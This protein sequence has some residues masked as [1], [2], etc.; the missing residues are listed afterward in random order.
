MLLA[1][2]GCV[3]DVQPARARSHFLWGLF[4]LA[5]RL[6]GIAGR[7]EPC[8]RQLTDRAAAAHSNFESINS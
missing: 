8:V 3:L 1:A 2:V 6:G 7:C 5:L 4:C